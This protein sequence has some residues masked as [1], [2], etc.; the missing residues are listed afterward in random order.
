MPDIQSPRITILAIVCLA[1]ILQF[2]VFGQAPQ[3][4][5]VEEALRDRIEQL[6]CGVD[7]SIESVSVAATQFLAAFYESR[8]F[9][10]AWTDA[11]NVKGL[12]QTLAGIKE[13]GLDPEDY[14]LSV[15]R[16]H[17]GQEGEIRRLAPQERA[18]IDILLTESLIRLVYH[19]RFGKVN[20]EAL[21]ANWNF[22][23]R[24]L[25]KDPVEEV[26]SALASRSIDRLLQ[27]EIPQLPVY[28]RLKTVLARY[29]AI[30]ASGG[31]SEI[32][33]GPGLKPGE[34]HDRVRVLR[35]RLI[36]GGDWAGAKPA[37]PDLFDE[38]L[39]QGVVAFQEKHGL[40]ADGI[41]GDE[42]LR[43]LN[44]SVD[45]RIG[46]IE[47][48]MERAR[49]MF[50]DIHLNDDYLLVDIAAFRAHLIKDRRKVW[51]ARVQVG[52]PYRKTPVFKADL[53]YLVFNPTWT[54]PPT[55]LAK[56]I[57]PRLAKDP[58]YLKEKRL[59]VL[60][61]NGRTVDPQ[62]IE[63]SR[64]S[65]ANFPYQLMQTPG[66]NNALGRVKFMFP[67]RHLVYLHDTPSQ[68]LFEKSERAFSSGCIRIQNA[69]DLAE[70]LLNDPEKWS[71]EAIKRVTSSNKTQTVM[72]PKPV[73][74]LLLY[75]TAEANEDGT[76]SFRKDIYGRDAKILKGLRSRFGFFSSRT[77]DRP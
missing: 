6:Q 52:Q 14:L 11:R 60:D 44:V 41:V 9:A 45:A 53:T 19:L 37:D 25:D 54:V 76:V 63:R 18:Q 29:R 26:E 38:P 62:N 46:Q 71:G 65:P 12:M 3:A 24:F 49:W 35:Q 27:N 70:I 28:T 2:S 39:R 67:N 31:W 42:T 72:I 5:P 32:P 66:Q 64:L 40:R 7:L 50:H 61:R 21:D 77:E 74:V 75:W 55:I 47:V 1:A 8:G 17:I 15:M 58:G 68:D 51:E 33:E 59:R 36:A 57:L 48:N 10:P 56:D 16:P 69:L 20:P 73:P 13:E 22:T 30:A 4:G 23:Q 43:A 34:K